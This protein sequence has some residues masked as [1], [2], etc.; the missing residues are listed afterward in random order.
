MGSDRLLLGDGHQLVLG[1]A[2]DEREL[3]DVGRA[4]RWRL[5]LRL[6]Q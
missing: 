2:Y 5:V 4:E 1:E 3:G 6:R